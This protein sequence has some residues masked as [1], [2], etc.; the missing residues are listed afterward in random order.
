M[1]YTFC[2]VHLESLEIFDNSVKSVYV[3]LFIQ[4]YNNNNIY[5]GVKMYYY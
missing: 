4:N 1:K 2:Q 3:S 5:Y